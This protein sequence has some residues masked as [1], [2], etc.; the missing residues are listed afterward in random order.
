MDPWKPIR[1]WL[2]IAGIVA[3]LDAGT[4]ATA[5]GLLVLK[6]EHDDRLTRELGRTAAPD[7]ALAREFEDME[8][9]LRKLTNQHL[10]RLPTIK[11]PK[12]REFA[13]PS[14]LMEV[15][16][17]NTIGLRDQVTLRLGDVA[18]VEVLPATGSNN[19]ALFFRVTEGFVPLQERQTQVVGRRRDWER[20]R[21]RKLR[22]WLDSFEASLKE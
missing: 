14:L 11:E 7:L 13:R 10:E 5:A 4:L 15:V 1:L 20:E 21:L 16:S 2:C 19:V 8:A 22:D 18:M 6:V 17:I 12:P 3:F 9:K